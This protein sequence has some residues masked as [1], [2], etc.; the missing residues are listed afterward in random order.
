MLFEE[1]EALTG[2][3]AYKSCT[4]ELFE[5]INAEHGGAA[6]ACLKPASPGAYSRPRTSPTSAKPRYCLVG[7]IEVLPPDGSAQFFH[8]FVQLL[9]H[10]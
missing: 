7:H 10:F 9:G 8:N 6:T 2:K 1:L 3:I 5:A 4:C